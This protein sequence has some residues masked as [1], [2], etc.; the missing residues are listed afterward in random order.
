MNLALVALGEKTYE[1]V[2]KSP[3]KVGSP[4]FDRGSKDTNHSA[5]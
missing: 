4:N 3:S 5:I 2:S 1:E